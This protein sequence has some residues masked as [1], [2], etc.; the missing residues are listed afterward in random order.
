MMGSKAVEPKLFLSFDLESPVP[1]RGSSGLSGVPPSTWASCL[2]WSS[3]LSQRS[4][5]PAKGTY[6]EL[7]TWG[8]SFTPSLL[9]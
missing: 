8:R 9:L 6:R 2:H 7:E 5:R 4:G 1:G 3:S